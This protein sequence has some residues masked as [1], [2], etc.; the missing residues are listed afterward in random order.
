M[1]SKERV[2]TAFHHREPD[3]VPVDYLANVEI[4]HAIKDHF[5]LAHEDSVGLVEK[6]GVDFRGCYVRYQ[7]PRLHEA[8]AGMNVNEWG[9]HTRWVEHGA[10]GYWDCCRFP[11]AGAITRQDVD[12]WPMPSPDDYAYDEIAEYCGAHADYSIVLGGA[13]VG[14]IM[15]RLGQL[16]GM[17]D[18]LCDVTTRD[19]VG[20]RLIERYQEVDFEVARRALAATAGRVH[21]FSM[22]EDL[23]TQTAPIVS[24]ETFRAVIRPRA[25]RFIDEAKRYGLLVMF[26]SCGSSSW[27]FDDLADMGVDIIDTLQPEAAHMEPGYLKKRFGDR[28]SFH[29]AISTCGALSFGTPEDVRT[30]VRRVLD[31]MMPGGGFALAP[32]QL[33]QSNSPV[34]N[35]LALYESAREMGVY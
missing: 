33:I 6:L 3:R 12:A 31:V 22:G 1:T 21:I 15:N 34:A 20:I 16:R 10:G 27:A 8:P 5:G 35:V 7:G 29:G 19:A 13:G 25:Q 9:I 23:G 28:L 14:C 30:E 32:S 18:V 26:H 11:L 24:P 17:Q 2:L 4:D